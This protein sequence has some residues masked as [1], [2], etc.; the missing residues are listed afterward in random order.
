MQSSG[1]QY[2][3]KGLPLTPAVAVTLILET[4]P[5]QTAERHHIVDTI[6]CLHK[7]R[8]GANPRAVDVP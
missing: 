1:E 2:P 6:V 5:G 7:A 3:F 4:F 8:G